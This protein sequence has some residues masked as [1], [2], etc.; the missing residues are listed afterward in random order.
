MLLSP[1]ETIL[2]GLQAAAKLLEAV[3]ETHP[4]VKGPHGSVLSSVCKRHRGLSVGERGAR[5]AAARAEAAGEPGEPQGPALLGRMGVTDRPP[6]GLRPALTWV[7]GP[8]T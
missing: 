3:K 1:G 7:S 8:G 5:P 4:R 6:L 2:N